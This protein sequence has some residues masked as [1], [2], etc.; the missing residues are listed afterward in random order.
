MAEFAAGDGVRIKTGVFAS[1]PGRVVSVSD[2]GLLLVVA[3]EIFGQT[4]QLHL[5]RW[6]VERPDQPPPPPPG[7][8]YLN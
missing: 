4:T 2:D 7:I 5:Q 3:V 1:F 6:E 8:D